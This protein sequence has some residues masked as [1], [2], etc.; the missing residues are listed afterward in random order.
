MYQKYKEKIILEIFFIKVKEKGKQKKI[1]I[2]RIIKEKGDTGVGSIWN[3]IM[4]RT[5]ERKI[6]PLAANL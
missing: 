1:K 2:E 6:P 5:R 4:E 3:T